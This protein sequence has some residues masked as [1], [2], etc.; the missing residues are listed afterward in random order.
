[1]CS[2]DLGNLL[3]GGLI[4]ATSTITSAANIGGAGLTAGSAGAS[5]TGNITGGNV[6]T[7]GLMSAAGNVTG[8]Y[9]FGNGSQLTGLSAAVSVS[10]IALGTSVANV[11]ASG[12]NI[13]FTVGGVSNVMVISTS[14]AIA[15]NIS[16]NKITHTGTN[17]KI[18]R[19]H[20]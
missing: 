8:L 5:V 10:Q 7:A 13:A 9:Y 17:A 11:T 20:V 2:S 6:L 16:V 12:G 18:G 14:D 15:A 1:M 19:A 3:T 4:S